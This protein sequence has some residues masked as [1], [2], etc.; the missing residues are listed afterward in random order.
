MKIIYI[1]PAL[2]IKNEN[3]FNFLKCVIYDLK[4]ILRNFFFNRKITK[5]TSGY[6]EASIHAKFFVLEIPY[7]YAIFFS[8]ILNYFFEAIIINWKFTNLRNDKY[9]NQKL[10]KI[11]DQFSIL[12]IIAD[13][14][15]T[16]DVEI[17]K[18]IIDRFNFIIKREKD[19]KLVDKKYISTML[20]C[21]LV[22][23]YTKFKNIDWSEIGKNKPNNIFKYDIFLSGRNTSLERENIINF[24]K[25]QN[26][27]LCHNL[28]ENKFP[29]N[30][31]LN[32][33]YCSAINLAPD[34][35]GKFTFRHLEILASCSFM[36]CDE[37]IKNLE[38]PLPIKDGIHYA[39]Y[40]NFNDLLNKIDFYLKNDNL[41]SEISLNGRKL[42]E[43]LYC[44]KKHG[45]KIYDIISS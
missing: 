26:Y 11:S 45:Q 37:E 42:L 4:I 35:I 8:K 20:P 31:Y 12:K 25:K 13:T 16:G 44:P 6:F 22:K 28:G 21:T 32:N 27:N 3:I 24:L 23:H 29:Y 7:K 14:R 40:K 33:I 36:L 39:S 10:F 43:N 30:D 38:L 17:E 41:R 5:N 2:K 34:G 9:F 15:D 19:K 1:P 18:T